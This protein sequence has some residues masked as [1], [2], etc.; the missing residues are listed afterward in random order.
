MNRTFLGSVSILLGIAAVMGCERHDTDSQSPFNGV[1]EGPMTVTETGTTVKL[2]NVAGSTAEFYDMYYSLVNGYT[3]KSK[4]VSE[5]K[6]VNGDD[7][8]KGFTVSLDGDEYTFAFAADD[9]SV[10]YSTDGKSQYVLTSNTMDY[11]KP[12]IY[13]PFLLATDK[14]YVGPREYPENAEA[15]LQSASLTADFNWL[16]F[17]EWA[18]KTAAT[19]A[20]GKGVG[21]LLDMLF[22]ASGE[23]SLDDV[24]DKLN[25]ITEQL[26]QMTLL[27]KNTTYEAKLNERSRYVSQL[28]NYNS[29]Y[30]IRLSHADTEE[31]VKTII[32]DWASH[33][34]GGNP[35]YVE[36]FNFIDFLLGTVVEQRDIYN[37]Y[38]LYTYNTT[39]WEN[40][41]Y[42][43]REALR[44][45]DIAVAAQTFYLTQLYQTLRTDIKDEASK[46]DILA[47]NIKNF[48]RFSE[49]LK[50]RPVERHSDR[51]ICQIADCHFVMDAV[52]YEV[53]PSGIYRNPSWCTLPHKWIE[54]DSDMDFIYGPNK[55]ERYNRSLT[56]D[57]ARK[58]LN[59]YNGTD[60]TLAQILKKAGFKFS[61]ATR[62]EQTLIL[63]LQ[64][65][66][67][68]AD[69][70]IV[71]LDYSVNY[72]TKSAGDVGPKSL[73]K[74]VFE[75]KGNIYTWYLQFTKWKTFDENQ[76]WIRTNVLE[77]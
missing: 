23:T 27:Y 39:A 41:G 36:C 19:T 53:V 44:A 40:E 67:Y 1:W 16:E 25:S 59:F 64:S 47:K 20:W 65:K 76:I 14:E 74:G 28:T 75:V 55:I 46:S 18:G 38:D 15:S 22:P 13:S 71:G 34:V 43:V 61:M 6:I 37:M 70:E 33:N 10:I 68:S 50:N 9:D 26:N 21:V 8:S 11:Y 4:Q 54:Y 2:I 56:P 31:D 58:I 5:M 12:V 32:L 35:P 17:L 77:R 24:L 66:G 52:N 29:D 30:Y 3:T 51:V 69:K 73:G 62:P 72:F 60:L 57:E 7:D 49:Y 45:S 48:E 63:T 42:A